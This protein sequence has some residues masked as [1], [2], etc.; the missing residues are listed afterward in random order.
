MNT[1]IY[2]MPWITRTKNQQLAFRF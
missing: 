2:D 1:I